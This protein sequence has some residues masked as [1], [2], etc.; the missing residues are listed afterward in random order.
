VTDY[1]DYV[2]LF[3]YMLLAIICREAVLW[4]TLALHVYVFFQQPGS[5]TVVEK[6]TVHYCKLLNCVGDGILQ[7]IM[8]ALAL[9]AAP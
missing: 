6:D 1:K 3:I 4:K 7:L 5:C 9:F 8:R 2:F